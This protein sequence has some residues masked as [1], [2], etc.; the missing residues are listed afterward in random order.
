MNDESGYVRRNVAYCEE[1]CDVFWSRKT[2]KLL[3][4]SVSKQPSCAGEDLQKFTAR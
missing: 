2:K 4:F 3:Q 1:F